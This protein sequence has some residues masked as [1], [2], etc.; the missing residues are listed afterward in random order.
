MRHLRSAG[1][2]TVSGLAILAIAANPAHAQDVA[3]NSAASGGEEIVVTAR[4]RDERAQDVP[5]A[6]S[7]VGGDLLTKTNTTSV[8][9]LSKL[10]PTL[11]FQAYNPR[12]TN[13]NIRHCAPL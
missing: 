3:E 12:N 9:D 6:L 5:I 2:C 8:A 4:H 13:L 10:A 7:V 1:F 11:S